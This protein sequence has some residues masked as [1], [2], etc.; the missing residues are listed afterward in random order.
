MSTTEDTNAIDEKKAEESGTSSFSPNFKGFINDYL[1]SIILT[2]CIPIFIIGGLGLYTTKVAQANIL[3][4]DIKLAPYTVIDRIID[5]CPIDINIMKPSFFADGDDCFS[6]KAVFNSK[7]YLDSF[8]NNFLCSMKSYADPKSFSFANIPL[9]FSNV[10]DNTVARTFL[11]INNV[12]FYL[13]YLPESLIMF[14][15]GTFG[16]FLW[17]GLFIWTYLWSA[18]YHIT[19]IPQVFRTVSEQNDKQWESM[20]NISFLRI[21]NILLFLLMLWPI[22]FSVLIVTPFI[23]IYGL[24]A[25]LFAT[26]KIKQTNKTYGIFDFIIDTFVYKKFFFLILATI[27]LFRNG[28]TNLGQNSVIGIIIAVIF[29]YFMGL[30]KNEM[31]ESGIDGFTNKIKETITRCSLNPVDLESPKLVEICQRIP[32]DDEKMENLIQKGKFR[33]VTKPQISGGQGNANAGFQNEN[34]KKNIEMSQIKL[35]KKELQ[36]ALDN[37]KKEYNNLEQEFKSSAE[38][39]KIDKK[40]ENI[41]EDIGGMKGGKRMKKNNIS[42]SKKYDIRWT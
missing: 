18:I 1:S 17:I 25:P 3:P 31:P 42:Q 19:H 4:D 2:I 16:I 37:L 28:V 8:S 34:D 33:R 35:G 36:E 7:E 9:Y 32:V 41:S 26:Y 10:Y 38:G 24:I 13:S 40:L 12:F 21:K 11:T 20:A 29:A 23:S 15:Y 22:M 14:L 30:Y 5:D 39:Q 27:S 6:Q